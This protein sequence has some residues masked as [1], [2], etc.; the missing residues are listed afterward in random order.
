MVQFKQLQATLLIQFDRLSQWA[1]GEGFVP[2]ADDLKGLAQQAM[3]SVGKLTSWIGTAL[4]AI[5]TLFMI[6]V[7]GLFVAMEPSIY[8]RGLQWM[9][10]SDHRAEF[11]LTLQRMATQL[12]R[13]LAGRLAG[14]AFEGV[15]MWLAL[16]L[17]AFRWRWCS[18]SSPAFSR[19]SPISAR[20]SAAC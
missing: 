19:S 6:M 9:V 2:G 17:P 1:A 14:M 12:R 13:L 16:A 7:I 20:S 5:T 4:G 3:G 10:P 18:A 11:A 15:F 8:D